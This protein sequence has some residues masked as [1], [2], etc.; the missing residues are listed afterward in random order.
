MQESEKT[1][2]TVVRS[3]K[4]PVFRVSRAKRSPLDPIQRALPIDQGWSRW[5]VPGHRTIYAGA[6]AACSY[7]ETLT[8]LRLRPSQNSLAGKKLSDFFDLEPDQPD[9]WILAVLERDRVDS[10]NTDAISCEWRHDRKLHTLSLPAG[11]WFVQ[12]DTDASISALR[13]GYGLD[14]TV[15]DIYS[16]DR[17]TTVRIAE[18]VHALVLDDGSLPHGILYRSKHGTNWNCWAIWL[19]ALDDGHAESSEPTRRKIESAILANDPNLAEAATRL[20]LRVH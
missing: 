19:R 11:G 8:D 3:Q 20:G 6:P 7:A 10:M 9:D 2:F 13:L 5:D 16:E 1:G 15:A 18:I 14:I 4:E 17:A 12:L